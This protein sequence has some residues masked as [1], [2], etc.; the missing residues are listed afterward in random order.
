MT[1]RP[2]ASFPHMGNYARVLRD[3]AKLV[4]CDVLLPPPITQ[5][6]LELGARHSPEFVCVPFKYN[7]GNFIEALDAG[8]TV[9][10]QA[11]GGCRF[12]YYGEVQEAILRHLGYDFDFVQISSSLDTR[13]IVSFV[14]RHNPRVKRRDV[15]EIL[16]LTL[17]KVRALDRIEDAVRRTIGFEV[18]EGSF[19]AAFEAFLGELEAA[20]TLSAVEAIETEHRSRIDA[21]PIDRP[22]DCLRVG[23]VGE[24]YVLMEPF[25]NMNVERYLARRGIE[26]HRFCTVTSLV[27]HALEGR[28]NIARMTEKTEPYV[29]Y[30]V[31]AEGTESVYLTL[32]L[33]EQGF[34]GVVHLKPFGCM[35]EVNAMSALQ[36]ISRENS[37]PVLF[38]SYDAQTSE[39]GVLTRV[40]AF[41]DMLEL[42]RRG[43]VHA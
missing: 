27:D 38:M 40:E 26:V 22:E 30:H 41:A 16:Q 9:L 8:A 24:L 33:M 17:A 21:L 35:P 23:V 10:I 18:E 12:S 14:R 29:R 20:E 3:L 37:F 36:R 19:D 2:I 25:S 15:I 1:A 34:D 11:G 43:R 7:L 42:R 28:G 13:G 5:R 4:E 31:G 32:S 39:T 6:T